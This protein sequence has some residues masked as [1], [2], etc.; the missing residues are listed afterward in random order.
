[1]ATDFERPPPQLDSTG[2]PMRSS[3]IGRGPF[4]GR[5]HE[6]A[7]AQVELRHVLSAEGRVLLIS[8]EPGVGKTRLAREIVGQMRS[9]GG[10]ALT[11]ECYAE[12]DVPYG[13]VARI[14]ADSFPEAASLA[15]EDP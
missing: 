15:L 5:R 4:I 12:A 2:S 14:I 8:G 3:S 10:I 7:E 6:L 13:P 11:G 9:A 1:M